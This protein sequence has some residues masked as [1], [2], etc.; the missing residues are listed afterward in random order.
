MG[1][2][3]SL[4]EFWPST[5]PMSS[6]REPRHNVMLQARLRRGGADEA[7]ARVR[8][9]S[10]GGM[11]AEC[12][13]R[14]AQGE[15]IEIVMRGLGELTGSVAWATKERVGVMF[16]APVDPV[17]VLRRQPPPS[18]EYVPQAQRRSWRP[19]LHSS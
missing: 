9:I 16:D 8:N 7:P 5:E 10:R 18:E 19:P 6:S 13:C 1:K 2:E 4:V 11:M 17:A 3:S 14:I 15:R 12:R